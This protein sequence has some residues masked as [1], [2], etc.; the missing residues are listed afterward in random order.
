MA[1]ETKQEKA[2]KKAGYS[3]RAEYF[4]HLYIQ[5]NKEANQLREE[6]DQTREALRTLARELGRAGGAARA[7]NLSKEALSKIG[8]AGA[9]K[10]WKSKKGGKP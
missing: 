5:K 6:R 7:K 2:I 1:K 3:G 9:A 10:R 8:R 4:A